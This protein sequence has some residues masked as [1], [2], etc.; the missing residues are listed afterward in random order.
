MTMTLISPRACENAF[1]RGLGF[2]QFDDLVDASQP[3]FSP[4]GE[5]WFM[6]ALPNGH[7]LAWPFPEYDDTHLFDSYEEACEFVS[8]SALT[9]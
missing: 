4:V 1:A 6:A 9:P 3:L 7:W 5:L 8:P 2:E